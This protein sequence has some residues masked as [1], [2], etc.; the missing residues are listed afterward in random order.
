MDFWYDMT[1]PSKNGNVIFN[2]SINIVSH[3]AFVRCVR[4]N[5]G[6]GG[7]PVEPDKPIRE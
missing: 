6:G 2:P 7:K 5:S 4:D 3:G 1:S